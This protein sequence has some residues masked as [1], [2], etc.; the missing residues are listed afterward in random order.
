[1]IEID[2]VSNLTDYSFYITLSSISFG[3]VLVYYRLNYSDVVHV[4]LYI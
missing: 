1:V 3:I 2:E 4:T